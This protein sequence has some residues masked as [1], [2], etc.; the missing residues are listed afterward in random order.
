MSDRGDALSDGTMCL[1]KSILG[2]S[3]RYK[4]LRISRRMQQGLGV[5]TGKL[6]AMRLRWRGG[7]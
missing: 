1:G 3:L 7:I 5:S 4:E 6:I 2:G